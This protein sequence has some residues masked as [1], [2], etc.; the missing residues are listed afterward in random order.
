MLIVLLDF[1]LFPLLLF[2][3]NMKQIHNL[4]Y[5]VGEEIFF[6]HQIFRNQPKISAAMTHPIN[7]IA[8]MNQSVITNNTRL[9]INLTNDPMHPPKQQKNT[10]N[11]SNMTKQMMIENK[12]S[13]FTTPSIKYAIHKH[14]IWCQ[15]SS[16]CIEN[17]FN[18][19]LK[20]KR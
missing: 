14:R 19:N 4:S 6:Y 2:H 8:K 11:S 17:V 10:S 20:E 1:S 12:N 5:S 16:N 18:Y 7:P 3:S 13:T 9:M 15:C